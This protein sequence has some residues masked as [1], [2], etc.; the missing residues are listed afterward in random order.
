MNR[1]KKLSWK[2]PTE[3]P[4][5]PSIDTPGEISIASTMYI[6]DSS[7]RAIKNAMGAYTSALWFWIN[8]ECE[9][10]VRNDIFRIPF[11]TNTLTFLLLCNRRRNFFTG[12]LL[13]AWPRS[14]N[15]FRL[16]FHLSPLQGS[17]SLSQFH[18]LYFLYNNTFLM[19][20]LVCFEEISLCL[21]YE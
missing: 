18:F 15:P 3:T 19:Y 13:S 1:L 17:L 8:C 14:C 20:N 4:I 2:N 16:L 7:H 6:C 5:S 21:N 10:I 9:G 11:H 12:S